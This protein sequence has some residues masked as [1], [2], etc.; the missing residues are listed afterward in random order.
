M[1]AEH[2]RR[3]SAPVGYLSE[4]GPVEANAVRCLRQWCDGE[5]ARAGLIADLALGLGPGAGPDAVNCLRGLCD[6]LVRHGRRPL[7]RHDVACACLGADEACFANLVAAAANGA[8]EDAMLM[9]TLMARPDQS[10]WIAAL[11]EDFGLALKRL[12]LRPAEMPS[13]TVH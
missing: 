4:L 11:A 5:S 7:M 6:L 3:G 1:S 8:R 2:A 10:P 9:A 12:A 13:G